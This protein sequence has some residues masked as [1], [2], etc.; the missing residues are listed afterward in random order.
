MLCQSGQIQKLVAVAHLAA[1]VQ[2]DSDGQ[3]DL[4]LLIADKRGL[5]PEDDV[6]VRDLVPA[7]FEFES[8]LE[9]ANYLAIN[10]IDCGGKK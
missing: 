7:Q 8:R 4:L 10:V 3:D 1:V 9:D 2:I 6:A 5:K